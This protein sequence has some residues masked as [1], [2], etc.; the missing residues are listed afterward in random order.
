MED[1]LRLPNGAWRAWQLGDAYHASVAGADITI[2]VAEI[3]ARHPNL[4]QAAAY[5]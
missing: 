1:G 2:Q 3:Q 4:D 5:A